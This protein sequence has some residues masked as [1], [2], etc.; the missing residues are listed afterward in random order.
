MHNARL[1]PSP[2]KA[3]TPRDLREA[4]AVYQEQSAESHLSELD[5]H[6]RRKRDREQDLD[7]ALGR[8][9]ENNK[10]LA[11]IF[12]GTG[13]EET[14]RGMV[15]AQRSLLVGYDSLLANCE[16]AG[17]HMDVNA[18]NAGEEPERTKPEGE[19]ALGEGDTSISITN[20]SQKDA[21]QNGTLLEFERSGGCGSPIR[22]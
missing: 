18:V 12:D 21:V 13:F 10:R 2:R 11:V 16:N 17:V 19:L 20:T 6:S 9:C 7:Q 5:L 8:Y 14:Y 3:P 1:T 4:L 15:E 22:L